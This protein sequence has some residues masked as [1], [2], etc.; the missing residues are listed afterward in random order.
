M[1]R[2]HD[3]I[4]NPSS[5]KENAGCGAGNLPLKT[6][7]L[8]RPI[9]PAPPPHA[10]IMAGRTISVAVRNA[11]SRRRA[12]PDCAA[13]HA[14][15][16]PAPARPALALHGHHW[17]ARV[18][19]GHNPRPDERHPRQASAVQVQSTAADYSARC[20]APGRALE[21]P[22]VIRRARAGC[23]LASRERGRQGID[24][25]SA[26]VVAPALVAALAAI[27]AARAT[28]AH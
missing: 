3:L 24:G 5:S 22:P 10:T 9:D 17:Q 26:R 25:R 1:S 12:P 2:P 6:T 4:L 14:T 15:R 21:T 7:H 11:G 13:G 23:G 20:V 27:L 28:A 16:Q 18:P 8:P 19:C